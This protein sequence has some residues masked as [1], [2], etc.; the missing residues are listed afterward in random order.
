MKFWKLGLWLV[1]GSL[2]A[3]GLGLEDMGHDIVFDASSGT[4]SSPSSWV[5]AVGC[6][7]ALVMVMVQGG[8]SNN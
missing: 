7:S 6:W 1:C 8:V 2:V 3:L 4:P 5:F